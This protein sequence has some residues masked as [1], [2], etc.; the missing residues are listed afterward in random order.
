MEK[1]ELEKRTKEELVAIVLNKDKELSEHQKIMEEQAEAIQLADISTKTNTAVVSY[2][3]K[4]YELLCRS[5]VF[6]KKEFSTDDLVNLDKGK[7]FQ[8]SYT[9]NGETK[10]GFFNL[11]ECLLKMNSP[12][13]K[14]IWINGRRFIKNAD[15]RCR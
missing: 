11:M 8:I 9:E 2:K 7:K 1:S 5:F 14:V 3:A 10:Q 6:Q 12:F 15:W 4:K 13:L